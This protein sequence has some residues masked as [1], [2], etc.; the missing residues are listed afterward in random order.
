M[1][2]IAYI[3][4]Q[5]NYYYIKFIDRERLDVIIEAILSEKLDFFLDGKKYY[6]NHLLEVRIFETDS[7]A[8]YNED[9]KE[10]GIK[11]DMDFVYV[12]GTNRA[13]IK[14]DTLKKIIKEVSGEFLNNKASNQKYLIEKEHL[15]IDIDLKAKDIFI[16]HSSKDKLLI[17]KFVEKILIL[18]LGLSNSNI[19]CTSTEGFGIRTGEDFRAAIRKNIS[20]SKITILI[21]SPN[22]KKSE[23]CLNEMGAAWVLNSHV[24]P[25]IIDPIDYKSV[26][27]IMEPLHI[28]KLNDS[29]FLDEL[30][31][32]IF[33]AL[34]KNEFDVVSWN[35][36]K[37]EFIDFTNSYIQL[38]KSADDKFPN[39]YFEQ[40]IQKNIDVNQLLNEAHPTKLDC[41]KLFTKEYSNEAFN[42]YCEFFAEVN[43]N[44]IRNL[45]DQYSTYK[46]TS[47][48]VYELIRGNEL[49]KGGTIECA[50]NNIFN[51]D[52]KVYRVDFLE[53]ENALHGFS[54]ELFTF[55]NNRVVFFPKPYAL[56]LIKQ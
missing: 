26:G 12:D 36:H 25:T 31:Q 20:E 39:E 15:H 19:F 28:S 16:S 2:Y 44:K 54:F 9:L 47:A 43:D 6:L 45:G 3:K 52:Q 27:T 24:I 35:K 11:V 1:K 38:L 56:G 33:K 37:Q 42:R 29:T 49:F 4:T 23:I 30:S 5:T 41:Q 50:K 17:D 55:Y 10:S 32:I 8:K 22:Y 53:D 48:N 14:P 46:I 40:F 21:I 34:D 18:G 7:E 51:I 13:Y